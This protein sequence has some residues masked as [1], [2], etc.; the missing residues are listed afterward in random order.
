MPTTVQPAFAF[1]AERHVYTL[2]GCEIPSVSRVLQGAGLF[3]LNGIDPK[4]LARKRALGEAVHLACQLY[5]EHDLDETTIDPLVR[6]RLD[7]WTKFCRDLDFHAEEIEQP[8]YFL[9]NGMPYAGTPDRR[10]TCTSGEVVIE[11]KCTAAVEPHHGVQLAAYALPHKHDGKSPLRFVVQ[12]LQD[13]DYKLHQ[14]TDRTDER[15][16]LSALALEHWK[17][18]KGITNIG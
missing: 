11:I 18:L 1:D 14:F 9:A 12:L 3:N 5:D 6:P 2:N 10:G 7:A 17:R 15:V 4:V 13:G 16:F 8:F